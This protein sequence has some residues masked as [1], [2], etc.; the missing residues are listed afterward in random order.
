MDWTRR[1]GV[2]KVRCGTGTAMDFD[3]LTTFLEVAKLGNFSRAGEKVF[4]SQSAVSAQI[5]QLEQ[6]YGAK[7]LDRSGKKVRLTAAGKVLFEYGMRLLALRDESLRAVVDQETMPG[8]VLAIGANEATCLY[9]LPNAFQ[10]YRVLYPEV[11]ISIYRN[12]SRKI[13]ERIHDGTIDVGIATL[14]V[15][16]PRLT[17]RR[18]FRDRLMLMV[19]PS[20]RLAGLSSVPL[21]MAAEQPFLFPKAGYTRQIM[22]KL[23]RPYQSK[24]RIAME[25]PSVAMIKTFVALGM[26]VS[27]ISESFARNEQRRGEVCLIPL[28]D[29]DLWRELGLVYDQERTLPR[30][31]AAFIELVQNGI[32][33]S[34]YEI[35]DEA[36]T[37]E[38]P[39]HD[40]FIHAFS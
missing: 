16:S 13:L 20:N 5:R 3:Q 32:S 6:D 4:R 27:L 18:I 9:V 34:G 40:D 1:S 14:P 36:S 38:L 12:F 21:S 22:D 7:L 19:S 37:S 2:A 17:V 24:L 8:G 28:A 15:K 10:K 26:G 39:R 30:S 25:L 29:V 33:Q 23:F 35:A 31:A 11:Q